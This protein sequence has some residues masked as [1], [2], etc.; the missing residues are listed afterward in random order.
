M[1]E[2]YRRVVLRS[3]ERRRLTDIMIYGQARRID[4]LADIDPV[5][6]TS[7]PILQIPA[8]RRR[9]AVKM[10]SGCVLRDRTR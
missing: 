9:D 5:N 8:E 7:V 1:R 6:D 4:A 3:S 2:N 10:A